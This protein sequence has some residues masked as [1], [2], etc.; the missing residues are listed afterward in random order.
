MPELPEVQTTVSGLYRFVR[1]L[2]IIDVWTEYNSPY[3]HGKDT[4]KDPKYFKYFKNKIKNTE[5]IHISRRAKN[6][7]IHLSNEYTIL[8]HMKM[9][10]HVMYGDYNKKDPYNR[11]IRLIFY[12]SNGKT[13][14]LCDTRKFAKVTLIET[15]KMNES[16]HLKDIG[17]EPL[18]KEFTF[19]IFKDQI[20]K[21][22]NG[23]IKL[24]LM[25]QSIIAGIGNIYADES[26]WRS[27]IHGESIVKKIPD[28]KLKELYKAIIST[29]SKGIDFGGD[30]MSDYRNIHGERGKFQEEHKAYRKTGT[31]C[32]KKGCNGKIIRTV[33]GGRGTHFC[34]THQ[35]IYK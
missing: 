9:T 2:S 25:D 23:K 27:G 8:I 33:I 14:E 20:N 12:L 1:G 10:G 35:K 15:A 3:F 21:K 24:V 4:I 13:I 29:L 34:N 31:K 26:L 18:E 11:F 6:I 28:K 30:S 19:P 22:P 16:I 7:L 32:S 5:I 17:P